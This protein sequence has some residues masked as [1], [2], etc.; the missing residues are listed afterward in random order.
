[1]NDEIDEAAAKAAEAQTET[2]PSW[3]L[4]GTDVEGQEVAALIKSGQP[5]SDGTGGGNEARPDCCDCAPSGGWRVKIRD[6]MLSDLL[7]NISTGFVVFNLFIMC[8]PY[9][10]QPI[11]YEIFVEGLGEFVT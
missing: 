4:N 1:M 5:L 2:E 9:A 3:T 7:G 10:G 6:V 8:L 11:E